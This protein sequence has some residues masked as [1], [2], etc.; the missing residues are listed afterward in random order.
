MFLVGNI[1]EWLKPYLIENHYPSWVYNSF[2]FYAIIFVAAGLLN[3]VIVQALKPKTD[4]EKEL[5]QL[6]KKCVGNDKA[7]RKGIQKAVSE[8]KQ[9]HKSEI[10]KLTTEY[11]R[12][13]R[14]VALSHTKEIASYEAKIKA[15]DI[16]I[17]SMTTQLAEKFQIID[18]YNKETA[19]KQ[20]SPGKAN[21]EQEKGETILPNIGEYT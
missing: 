15:K 7:S 16:L 17:E 10:T 2:S 18:E 20:N 13:K 4:A 8:C 3:T 14:S 6:R 11:N 1:Q 21:I 5:I 12:D 19:T 9:E